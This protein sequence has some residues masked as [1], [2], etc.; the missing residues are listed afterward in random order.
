[1]LLIATLL[2]AISLFSAMKIY[3]NNDG[4]IPPLSTG[5]GKQARIVVGSVLV[6]YLTLLIL[7]VA[8]STSSGENILLWVLA[9]ILGASVPV[10]RYIQY[11]N[12]Q[13][14]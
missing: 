13:K 10:F 2:A 1:M 9:F 4:R 8:K 7:N 6:C 12:K 14:K 5:R 11:K 3:S